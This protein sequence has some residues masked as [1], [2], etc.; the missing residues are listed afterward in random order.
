M[1]NDK[2]SNALALVP[3]ISPRNHLVPANANASPCNALA[4]SVSISNNLEP[5][6][7]KSPITLSVTGDVSFTVDNK[8]KYFAYVDPTKRC[9]S[10]NNLSSLSSVSSNPDIIVR[11]INTALGDSSDQSLLTTAVI[12]DE[13]KVFKIYR[14]K[15]V[16]KGGKQMIK[17]SL[18][19]KELNANGNYAEETLQEIKDK[20]VY[21]DVVFTMLNVNFPVSISSI[22]ST[23]NAL[24]D[25]VSVTRAGPD[26]NWYRAGLPQQPY[27]GRIWINTPDI[28]FA[29]AFINGFIVNPFIL[30]EWSESTRTLRIWL[31]RGDDDPRRPARAF[32]WR[33]NECRIPLGFRPGVIDGFRERI[34]F[35]NCDGFL[36][37]GINDISRGQ[38]GDPIGDFALR[39]CSS[40]TEIQQFNFVRVIEE[41]DGSWRLLS[42]SP[43]R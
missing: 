39:S 41:R 20:T 25:R 6:F 30:G 10:I 22:S 19:N 5:I 26:S 7:T 15:V 18:S 38:C 37:V 23:I 27:G 29:N 17:L 24:D 42:T 2:K 11:E 35:S 33:R 34:N 9:L 16:T 3:S 28:P 1:S 31:R 43:W 21:K 8:N 14:A 4:R 36:C 12:S 40:G 32:R 13:L